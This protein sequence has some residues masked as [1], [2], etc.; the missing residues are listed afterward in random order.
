[1]RFKLLVIKLARF[2]PPADEAP[3][4][5]QGGYLTLGYFLTGDYR[6]YNQKTASWDRQSV[7]EP[8]FVVDGDQRPTVWSRFR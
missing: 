4:L 3:W 1:M 8:A 5:Y 7:N 2:Y 6:P